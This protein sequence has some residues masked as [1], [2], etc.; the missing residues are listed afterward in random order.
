MPEKNVN[1]STHKMSWNSR[2]KLNFAQSCKQTD[3][4]KLE[5]T[6]ALSEKEKKCLNYSQ[7]AIQGNSG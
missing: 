4:T 3:I 7:R 6:L 1:L 5:G 2:I